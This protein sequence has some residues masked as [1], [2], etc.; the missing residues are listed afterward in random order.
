MLNFGSNL[1]ALVL[2]L[3]AG[4]VVWA[5]GA[6]M[7]LGQILGATAGS[8][9]MIRSGPRLMG[10]LIVAVCLSMLVRYL[11]QKGYLVWL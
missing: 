9:V 7:I 4:K 10:L 5:Y 6:V 1:G 3:L 11:W 2:F 8:H